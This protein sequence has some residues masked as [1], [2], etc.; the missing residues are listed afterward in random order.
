[1]LLVNQKF[2]LDL[3]VFMSCVLLGNQII[4]FDSRVIHEYCVINY[5][6]VRYSCALNDPKT[7][8]IQLLIKTKN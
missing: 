1:M 6:V 7:E 2:E 8:Y 4:K 3:S 5:L